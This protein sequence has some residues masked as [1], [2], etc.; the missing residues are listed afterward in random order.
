MP[1]TSHS[2]MYNVQHSAASLALG[3][4]GAAMLPVFYMCTVRTVQAH[5]DH[6]YALTSCAFI[7]MRKAKSRAALVRIKN[8]IQ[9]FGVNAK[10]WIH[11]WNTK[12]CSTSVHICTHKCLNESSLGLVCIYYASK[13]TT[14][15]PSVLSGSDICTYGIYLFCYHVRWRPFRC[16][17]C[18]SSTMFFLYT[19]EVI[20]RY[21]KH[22][23][24]P[25][26]P[27]QLYGRD[28]THYL[29]VKGASYHRKVARFITLEGEGTCAFKAP[30]YLLCLTG[31]PDAPKKRRSDS[32][33]KLWP[34]YRFKV[35][36]TLS[37][38][39]VAFS[40]LFS[41]CLLNARF[42]NRG[43]HRSGPTTRQTCR[44]PA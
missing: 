34:Y 1:P 13:C 20:T 33:T 26:R 22:A 43:G 6:E 23:T 32:Y 39:S 40:P 12:I 7:G 35:K 31:T 38:C 27:K 9:L 5:C 3:A 41:V 2:V 21:L 16:G 25:S 24:S 36:H 19:N 44:H 17:Y 8:V 18:F 29:M 14:T 4:S 30:V 37:L 10:G 28:L 11:T 42:C 15:V